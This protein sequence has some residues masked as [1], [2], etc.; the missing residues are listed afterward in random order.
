MAYNY[1]S[2]VNAVLARVNEVPLTSVNFA[3]ASGFYAD[4]KNA[5]NIAINEIN[6]E[7]FEWPFN[8]ET[9]SVTLV[10]DQVRYNLPADNKT[11]A[12]DTF[13]IRGDDTL[14]NDTTSLKPVDY[15]EYLEKYSDMEY[16]PTDY[17]ALPTNVVRT[18]ELTYCIIPPADMAYTLDFEYYVLPTDLED[19][20]DVP[21]IPE[22]FKHVIHNGAMHYTYMFRGD[23]EAAT[24]ARQ[25][26]DKQV[27]SMRTLFTNRTEYARSTFRVGRG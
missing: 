1:L 27:A 17:S 5:V 4:V 12:W 7:Q 23:N 16:R 2:L 8:H 14:L 13:R 11:V 19:Y 3:D 22:V 10:A 18:R 15:E 24:I 6:T 26:F 21:R 9:E 25:V 20:D